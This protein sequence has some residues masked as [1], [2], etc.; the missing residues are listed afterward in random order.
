MTRVRARSWIVLVTFL[1][2]LALALHA[3]ARAP[4]TVQGDEKGFLYYGTMQAELYLACVKGVDEACQ[5]W[6]W[7]EPYQ[8]YGSHNPKLGLYALGVM[9]HATRGLERDRRIPTMRALMGLISSLA[10]AG[11]AWLCMAAGGGR[12][13]G[14][15]AAA[16]LLVHPVFRSAQVALLP[17]VPM[18]LLAV[19]ALAAS[20]TGLRARGWPQA[21]WLVLAGI[22]AGL[23]LACKLYAVALF[24]WMLAAVLL[25]RLSGWRAWLA[26]CVG[27]LGGGLAFVATNPYLWLQPGEALRALTT[28]HV[29]AQ[30]GEPLGWGAGLESLAASWWAPFTLLEPTMTARSQLQDLGPGLGLLVGGAVLA[31]GL[32]VALARRRW[33][34]A[35]WLLFTTGLAAYVVSRFEPAWLY[36]RAFLLPALGLAWV[37]GQLDASALASLSQRLGARDLARR[38]GG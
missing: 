27:W 6:R 23:A 34:P 3:A 5:D 28:G 10:V 4:D 38:L 21:A 32:A 16:C 12:S 17:D 15:L 26:V 2:S 13:T 1:V 19:L 29:V 31:L 24:P 20:C 25:H 18:V 35:I 7:A 37:V 11:L 9:D 14:L 30:G 8:G 36:P 22:L 33:L